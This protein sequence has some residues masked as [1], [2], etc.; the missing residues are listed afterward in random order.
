MTH[1]LTPS[2]VGHVWRVLLK[3]GAK[4]HSMGVLSQRNIGSKLHHLE[5]RLLDAADRGR[6]AVLVVGAAGAG[7][8]GWP[9]GGRRPPNKTMPRVLLC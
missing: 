5:V 1:V 7:R 3:R 8:D 4:T 9:E 6:P 2:T